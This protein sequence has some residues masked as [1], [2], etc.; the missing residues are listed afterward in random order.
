MPQLSRRQFLKFAGIALGYSQMP[1]LAQWSPQAAVYGRALYATLVHEHPTATAAVVNN[2]WPDSVIPL[3]ETHQTWYRVQ[4]GYVERSALQPM[5]P[6]PPQTTLSEPPFWAEVTA[7]V[8][9]VW[10]WCAVDAPLVTRIGHGGAVRII[11]CLPGW[12]AIADEKDNLLGWSQAANWSPVQ[13]HASDEALDIKIDGSQMTVYRMNQFV[14]AAPV[15][16]SHPIPPGTYVLEKGEIG[17]LYCHISARERYH[18]ASWQLRFGN[19][20]ELNSVYWHNRFGQAVPGPSVQITPVLGRWLYMT[21]NTQ[22]SI[23]IQRQS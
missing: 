6:H 17:G 23:T 11:D 5:T 13:S 7:P 8:A 9:P 22:S 15:S 12:Y 21:A 14:A 2:L 16:I 1:G 3:V 19:D 4:D 18:G 20:F 10:Q